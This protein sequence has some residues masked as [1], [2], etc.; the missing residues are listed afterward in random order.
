MADLVRP[1]GVLLISYPNSK[2]ILRYIEK[3]LIRKFKSIFSRKHYTDM[4][5]QAQYGLLENRFGT[6]GFRLQQTR[7]FGKKLV[8]NGRYSSSLRLDSYIKVKS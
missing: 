5:A 8:V 1:G 7:Y 6:Q 2:S 3:N 4:Q